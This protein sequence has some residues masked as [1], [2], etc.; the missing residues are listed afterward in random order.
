MSNLEK[1]NLLIPM[2]EIEEGAQQQIFRELERDDLIRMAIMPDVHQGYEL[3]IGAVALLDGTISAGYVGYDIGCGMTFYN[4]RVQASDMFPD[5]REKTRVF[6]DIYRVVP[7]GVGMGHEDEQIASYKPAH[8][9]KELTAKAFPKVSHQ[10]GSLGGGNHFIEIGANRAGEVCITIHSGSRGGGW[11]TANWY[12]KQN[13]FFRLESDLGQAYLSDMNFFLDYALKSR[14]SMIKMI[15]QKVLGLS[16]QDLEN[17]DNFINENHN[18]AEI[19][20]SGVLHRKGATQANEGQMGVIPI[21]MRDG[22]YI[23][24]GLGNPTFLNSSSHGA[25]RRYSRTKAKKEISLE[26]FQ[27]QMKGI[28]AKVEKG[29]IDESP[30]AYKDPKRVI[31]AQD[32]IVLDVVDVVLPIINVKAIDTRSRKKKKR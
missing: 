13:K 30:N 7:M 2:E 26:L 21:S 24:K 5:D 18:H 4:T 6:N 32:G 11:D 28:V 1:L 10:F 3:P 16:I 31:E 12:M 8:G 27:E 22:V 17:E 14:K 15:L 19:T 25:G 9:D 23:T 20:L 29:T